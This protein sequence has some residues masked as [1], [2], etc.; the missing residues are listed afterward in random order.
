[1]VGNR[2]VVGV[3]NS[4]GSASITS[5]V[6]AKNA[7]TDSRESGNAPPHKP[8]PRNPHLTLATASEDS[9]AAGGGATILNEKKH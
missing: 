7:D 4:V 1:M 6:R 8:F 5:F 9:L 2:P 3:R